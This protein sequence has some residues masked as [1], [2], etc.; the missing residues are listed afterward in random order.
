MTAGLRDNKG[1]HWTACPKTE[2]GADVFQDRGGL[3]AAVRS[4]VVQDHDVALVQGRGRLGLDIEVEEFAVHPLPS[5]ASLDAREGPRRSPKARPAGH[6]LP[7]GRYAVSTR[8]AQGGDEGLSVPVAKGGVIDQTCPALG[9]TGRLGHVGLQGS[10]VNEC[11]PC[12]HVAHER[13]AA[14]DPY[15][16]G[17]CDVRPLLLDRP[18]VF[19]CVSGQGRADA[20][21]PRRGG[22]RRL[23]RHVVRSPARQG[24]DRAFP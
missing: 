19:F 15:P 13:L 9:P 21:K 24:S 10:L 17:Q 2:P 18:Q 1:V 3:R 23:G 22:P 11:Q 6:A 16:A 8:Q 7:G 5:R 20:A 12:Q 14:T 4:E